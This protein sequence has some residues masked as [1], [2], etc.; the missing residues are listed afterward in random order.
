MNTLNIFPLD[1]AVFNSLYIWQLAVGTDLEFVVYKTCHWQPVHTTTGAMPKRKRN[2]PVP[3]YTPGVG[4]ICPVY[5]D[6]GTL[7]GYKGG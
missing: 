7:H 4:T 3:V 2:I 6:E 1:R 5:D